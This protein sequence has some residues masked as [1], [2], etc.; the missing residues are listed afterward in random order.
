MRIPFLMRPRHVIRNPWS[1][2][3]VHAFIFDHAAVVIVAGL[4]AF[5]L[6]AGFM[7]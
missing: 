2:H 4:G 3:R 7:L 1:V 5:L 6:I